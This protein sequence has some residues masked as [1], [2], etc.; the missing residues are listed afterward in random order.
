MR[1]T[2]LILVFIFI[3]GALYS[4]KI[5]N[6]CGEYTYV[7]TE[8]ESIADAKRVASERAKLQALD[9]E[10]GSV[11]Y[12]DNTSIIKTSEE[13]SSVDFF[14]L[15]G[16]TVKGEWLE[17]TSGPDYELFLIDQ[18]S[19]MVKASICG[20]SREI[21]RASID[22]IAKILRGSPDVKNESDKFMDGN[23]V[24]LY[25]K[26][27]IK[28]YLAVYLVDESDNASCLLPY[29]H[30]ELGIEEVSANYEYI[31]FHK[32]DRNDRRIDSYQLNCGDRPSEVNYFYIIFSPN[33][34]A[35]ANDND[36][37]SNGILLPRQTDVR[38]FQK[39]LSKARVEDPAM[40]VSRKSIIITKQ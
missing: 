16:S 40:Q 31:F 3:T 6:I 37:S 28:G 26:T 21:K 18:T 32:K 25:F 17:T 35:K 19:F 20:K 9:G 2:I 24:F 12:Q 7:A 15:S 29:R 1:R 33:K 38:S 34:F 13:A 22:Y 10:Y 8:N 11:V 27:P 36:H 14:S 4:Q 30:N 23:D 5:K 39:W